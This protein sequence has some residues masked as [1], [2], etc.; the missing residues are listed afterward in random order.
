MKFRFRHR[1]EIVSY[2]ILIGFLVFLAWLLVPYL[3]E[4][5]PLIGNLFAFMIVVVILVVTVSVGSL[6][7]VVHKHFNHKHEV[8]RLEAGKMPAN[9]RG[10]IGAYIAPDG[11]L[12][13]A[14]VVAHSPEVP[15]HVHIQEDHSNKGM[16]SA[17][18]WRE[19][20]AREK[21]E[22]EREKFGLLNAPGQK[23]LP[24]PKP[25]IEEIVNEI[26]SDELEIC[27][28]KSLTTGELIK[29]DLRGKHIKVIGGTQM[30]KSCLVAAIIEQ[31]RLKHDRSRLLLAILDLEDMTGLLFE[32]DPH[33]VK[34]TVDGVPTLLHA[35][36]PLEVAQHIILLHKIMLHRY[37]LIQ[38]KGLGYVERQPR[39]LCYFEEFL[40][41]KKTLAQ[42]VPDQQMQADAIAAYTGIS[43][44]GLKVGM[45]LIVAAQVDY[46]DK[47]LLAAMAQFVGV[48]LS[49]AVKPSAARSA[50]FIATELL[51]KNFEARTP[52]QYVI[53]QI[54]GADIGVSPHFDVKAKINAL[55]AERAG[56]ENAIDGEVEEI[57]AWDDTGTPGTPR[58]ERYHIENYDERDG[59]LQGDFE[60]KN[61]QPAN[62]RPFPKIVSSELVAPSDA[63]SDER[64]KEYRLS[65]REIAQF[66]AAYKASGSIDKSLSALGRGARYRQHANEILTAYNARQA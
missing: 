9:E 57:E 27:L 31:L 45:H 26:S 48:N 65:E 14:H 32:N 42:N 16:G 43:T 21:L 22:W 53:E 62:V 33:I 30:G 23:L 7:F 24:S 28:G 39:I 2:L 19:A 5:L 56:S 17:A 55:L 50:G 47:D 20:L 15:A 12:I 3:K 4:W 38:E 35:R 52:G 41:W 29:S 63:T 60:R 51:N 36:T 6:P 64:P 18:D 1:V 61:N 46:A 66:L 59:T 8:A 10:Y 54:G 40:Y 37:M 58:G 49:F 13:S 11:T 34:L 25:T 44:R